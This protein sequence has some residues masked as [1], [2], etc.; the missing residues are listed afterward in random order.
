M[1]E[2]KDPYFLQVF[3]RAATKTLSDL[4]ESAQVAILFHMQKILGAQV[5]DLMNDP[6]KFAKALEQMFSIGSTVLEDKIIASMCIDI[7][8]PPIDSPGSFDQKITLVYRS[9]LNRKKTY[10]I[11]PRELCI[12][13]LNI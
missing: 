10:T 2:I 7:G 8:V 4:G 13:E 3:D 1:T 5:A 9:F 12:N 11:A 6:L